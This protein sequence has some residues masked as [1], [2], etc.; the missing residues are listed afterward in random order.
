[1]H[2]Q[3]GITFFPSGGVIIFCLVL[4]TVTAG[5]AVV[6]GLSGSARFAQQAGAL[7]AD[8]L[9]FPESGVKILPHLSHFI[10]CTRSLEKNEDILKFR[11]S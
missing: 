9:L 2:D 7:A 1:M 5:S 11:K 6:L 3:N 4:V 10:F 8:V